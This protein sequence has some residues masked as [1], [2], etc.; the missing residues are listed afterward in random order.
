MPSFSEII[1]LEDIHKGCPDDP[2]PRRGSGK[3]GQNRTWG[4]GRGLLS[5]AW[6]ILL[7]I[8]FY[9]RVVH[10]AT[11]FIEN[12]CIILTSSS[13]YSRFQNTFLVKGRMYGG[14]G[15]KTSDNPGLT[16]RSKYLDFG[17]TS[18]MDGPLTKLLIK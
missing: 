1:L 9:I 15:N 7:S 12:V 10:M 6:C 13:L 8:A 14:G 11:T 18:F 3:S 2:S 5:F 16:G 4:G 17:R